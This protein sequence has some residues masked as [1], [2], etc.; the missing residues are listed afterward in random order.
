MINHFIKHS[1]VYGVALKDNDSNSVET[2]ITTQK[3]VQDFF[4]ENEAG[5]NLNKVERT[6]F[7][8][9]NKYTHTV[10]GFQYDPK[11]L[12]TVSDYVKNLEVKPEQ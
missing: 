1:W 5:Y 3:E 7:V 10:W 12:L 11:Q 6:L 4:E 9:S 8:P 2:V